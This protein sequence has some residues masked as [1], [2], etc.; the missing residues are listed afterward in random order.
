MKKSNPTVLPEPL[1]HLAD[2]DWLLRNMWCA[3]VLFD[4]VFD[5]TEKFTTCRFVYMN[6]ACAK[7]IGKKNA[8]AK[9]KTLDEI[10]PGTDRGWVEKFAHVVASGE[11]L[12]FDDIH[13]ATERHFHCRV[14]CPWKK[15]NLFAVVF[16]D[17]TELKGIKDFY[18][19]IIE[20][21]QDGVW[22]TDNN[23]VI[24][25][26]NDIMAEISGVPR[27]NILGNNVLR[28]F[29]RETIKNMVDL[30]KKAKEGQQPLKYNISV[31]TPAGRR[32]RQSGW[33]IPHS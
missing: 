29:P 22:V 27:D 16:E 4:P 26:A 17:I 30:Y 14:F 10:W 11:T 21:I 32:T 9:G 33:L 7:I 3:F 12:E 13:A 18:E 25:Y 28:D 2:S 6:D 5:E 20:S 31:V 24:Y 19:N 1:T 15:S 23:D 8:E